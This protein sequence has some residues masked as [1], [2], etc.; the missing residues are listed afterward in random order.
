MKPFT[1]RL[2]ALAALVLLSTSLASGKDVE[3]NQERVAA[4]ARDLEGPLQVFRADLEAH[5]APPGKEAAR[6]AMMNDIERLQQKAN[7]LARRLASGAG[8]ADTL[9]LFH[10]VEVLERQAAKRT[11]SYPPAGFDMH[12]YVDQLDGTTNEMRRYYGEYKA[13]GDWTKE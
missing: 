4:L 8:R 2:P 11:Q 6:A 7:E 12:R 1:S 10:D 3:W 9:A 13:P 5:P